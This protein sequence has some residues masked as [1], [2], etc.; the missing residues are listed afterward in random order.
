MKGA[1]VRRPKVIKVVAAAVLAI[2]VAI[3]AY[4]WL[5]RTPPSDRQQIL[6]MFLA[7]AEAVERKSLSGVMRHISE[8]YDDGVYTK[9]ELRR[10]AIAGFRRSGPIDVMAQVRSLDIRGQYATATVEA[11]YTAGYDAPESTGHLVLRIEVKKNRGR[12]QVARAQGW[13]EAARGY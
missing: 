7:V 12:W 9:R 4:Y 1:A 13:Q 8:D 5:T 11:D 2:V 6:N 10:L 3:A